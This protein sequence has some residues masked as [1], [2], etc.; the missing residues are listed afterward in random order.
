MPNWIEGTWRLRGSVEN[1]VKYLEEN[2]EKVDYDYSEG[3][4]KRITTPLIVEHDKEEKCFSIEIDEDHYIG[5]TIRGFVRY[6]YT[7]IYYEELRDIT[8]IAFDVE[9][10]W[11]YIEKDIKRLR[12]IFKKYE[13]DFRLKAY[14]KGMGFTQEIEIINGEVIKFEDREYDNYIWDCESPLIG[15]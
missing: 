5:G 8:H 10:A 6:L 15:G 1:L 4:R 9:K 7:E 11:G 2:L 13:I 14:E 3:F 12:D